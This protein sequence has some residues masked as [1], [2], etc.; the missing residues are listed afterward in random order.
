MGA[1]FFEKTL[2]VTMQE[3][4]GMK[5]NEKKKKLYLSNLI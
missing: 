4:K 2:Q 5:I 1:E 3:V